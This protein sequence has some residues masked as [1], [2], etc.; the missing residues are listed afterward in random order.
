[1]SFD[2]NKYALLLNEIEQIAK[3]S[4]RLVFETTTY[5]N[6]RVNPNTF[7]ILATK[8]LGVSDSYYGERYSGI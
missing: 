8:L 2:T 4:K 1:M 5:L 3:V 7:R 6:S